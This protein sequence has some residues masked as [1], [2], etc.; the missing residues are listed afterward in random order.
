MKYLDLRRTKLS[1]LIGLIRCREKSWIP[2]PMLFVALFTAYGGGVLSD[3]MGGRRKIFVYISGGI[4]A[5]SSIIS[6]FNRSFA[7]EF[8]LCIFFGAAFGLFGSVDFALVC[9]V[10]PNEANRAKDM[11][12]W[13]IALVMP[14]FIAVPISG[15]ILDTMNES[16]GP[17][18]A[19]AVI[20]VISCCYFL[21]GAAL[22]S[23]VKAAK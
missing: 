16:Q 12:L 15:G 6:T 10:L 20:F 3:R 22:V 2:R 21:L 11:A 17:G 13:H 5:V 1:A 7:V 14:Q 8:L 23:K 4:M 9:D 18:P 19:Y